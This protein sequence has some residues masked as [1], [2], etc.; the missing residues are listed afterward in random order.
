MPGMGRLML[1]LKD[2]PEELN[3]RAIKDKFLLGVFGASPSGCAPTN[4]FQEFRLKGI[5]LLRAWTTWGVIE[6]QE[7][8]YSGESCPDDSFIDYAY[9]TGTFI[10]GAGTLFL[11]G[12]A[13]MLPDFVYHRPFEEQK[14]MAEKFIRAV[15]QRFPHI[16][17]W[18]LNEP[19]AQNVLELSKEQNYELFVSASHW[20]HETNSQAKVLVNMIPIPADWSTPHYDPNRVMDDL[21]SRGIEADIIG[22]ELYSMF[23]GSNK[24][25]N[26]YP[27]FDWVKQRID[28]FRRYG[29]PILFS[30]V[31]VPG[32]MNNVEQLEKQADWL[33]AFLRLAHDDPGVIGATWWSI[34]DNDEFIPYAG[35]TNSDNTFRPTAERL[36]KLAEEWN[37]TIKHVLNGQNYLELEP[38]EYDVIFDQQLFRVNVHIGE[39]IVISA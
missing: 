6:R 39:T 11:I 36:C 29:L 7:G 37:P 35:L 2:I 26:G 3:I 16:N 30:E 10:D 33:E 18:T 1:N 25:E 24:D 17:S 22:I 15:V 14:A 20:I 9:K 23:A 19:I 12:G 38:G 27:T 8:N 13:Y 5:N 31:G 32:N 21:I 34:Q 28:I 4:L